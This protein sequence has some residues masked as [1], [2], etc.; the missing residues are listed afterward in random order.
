MRRTFEG[1]STWIF[2]IAAICVLGF[3]TRQIIREQSRPPKVDLQDAKLL[4]RMEDYVNREH[5]C[6]AGMAAQRREYEARQVPFRGL[7][8]H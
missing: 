8:R 2:R 7:P 3:V 5:A 4:E 6:Q 1:L